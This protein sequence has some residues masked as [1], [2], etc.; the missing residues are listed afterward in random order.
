MDRFKSLLITHKTIFLLVLL[1]LLTSILVLTT[2]L[3]PQL[4][5]GFF[6]RVGVIAQQIYQ[7]NVFTEKSTVKV[8]TE[9]KALKLEFNITR[10][11][12][13]KMQSFNKNL[14]IDDD[15]LKGVSLEL[16]DESIQRLKEFLPLNIA[17][18]IEPNKVTF[19]SSILPT[20]ASS[21]IKE[22][23]EFATGEGKLKFTKSTDTEFQLILEN[24]K[25]L[26]QY[27]TESG[28][29]MMS[30]KLHLLFPILDRVGTIEMLVNGKSVSGEIRLK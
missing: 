9:E 3:R 12:K 6:N 4:L 15:Y 13:Q 20:F 10:E 18:T 24:P 19:G 25:P 26:L 2:F 17:L 1:I 8:W 30:D 27:A 14:N 21:L 23:K 5:G 16:D 22:T 29:V 7:R 28:K 11:D